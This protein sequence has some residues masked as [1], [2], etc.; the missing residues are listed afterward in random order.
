MLAENW[1]LFP[2]IFG[3]SD[4]DGRILPLVP[5]QFQIRMCTEGLASKSNLT[6]NEAS[7]FFQVPSGNSFSEG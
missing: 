5:I 3:L 7:R 1:K 4:K 6:V 2:G